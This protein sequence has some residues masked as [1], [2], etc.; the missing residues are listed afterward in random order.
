MPPV[1]ANKFLSVT[2]KSIFL[3]LEL[4]LIFNIFISNASTFS[5]SITVSIWAF[6]KFI[7]S[8]LATLYSFS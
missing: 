7:S 3:V 1:L 8:G 5:P 4:L 2:S 6:P